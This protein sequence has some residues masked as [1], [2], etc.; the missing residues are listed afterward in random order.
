MSGSRHS[1][2]IVVLS[3][4]THYNADVARELYR[5]NMLSVRIMF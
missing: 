5:W 4:M 1:V 3:A 2:G